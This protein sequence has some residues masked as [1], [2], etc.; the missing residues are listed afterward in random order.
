MGHNKKQ[1]YS[2]YGNSRREEEEKEKGT[3]SN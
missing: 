1:K 3:K 2:Y